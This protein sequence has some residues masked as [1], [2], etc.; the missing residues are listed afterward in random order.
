MG[1]LFSRRNPA[2]QEQRRSNKEINREMAKDAAL[3]GRIIKLLLLGTGDSGK[4]TIMKQV[5][6][7][8][9]DGFT[10]D[11]IN[12][13]RTLIMQNIFSSMR[14]LIEEMESLGFTFSHQESQENAKVIQ[15][16]TNCIHTT[17]TNNF[18]PDEKEVW[19]L[20]QLWA[21]HGIQDCFQ[22]RDTFQ[23]QESVQYFFDHFHRIMSSGYTPSP[24][25]ILRIRV[26]TTGIIEACF[27]IKCDQ[28]SLAFKL[29]DVGG[30]R[31]ERRKWIH[32]FENVHA[33]LFVVAISEYN[34]VLFEDGKTNRMWESLK[35]F[36]SIVNNAF[37][38]KTS[39]ILFLNKV[40]LFEE[41]IDRFPLQNF[42]QDY[43]G[44]TE[45]KAFIA[46]QYLGRSKRKD[47]I[48]HHFTC[49]TDTQQIQHLFQDVVK[50]IIRIALKEVNMC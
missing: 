26:P 28:M 23:L 38:V 11:E 35:L 3:E 43:D 12:V 20:K 48:Y 44:Q 34:Q 24:Q 30:Q 14:A 13:G 50:I 46:N 29:I 41:K 2:I 37:F 5:K 21:D 39:F 42:V 31:S 47:Q 19:A 1:C 40:D 22:Q 15:H 33:I 6:I 9:Q 7:V 18:Q 8:H 17:I 16:L 27:Q 10:E 32:C 4:S 45:P 49:A 36:E 25:D